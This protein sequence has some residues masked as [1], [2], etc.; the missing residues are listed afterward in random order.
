[1]FLS[2]STHD[3]S[4]VA[5]VLSSSEGS[6]WALKKASCSSVGKMGSGSSLKNCFTKPAT[7]QGRAVGRHSSP[8][9]SLAWRDKKQLCCGRRFSQNFEGQVAEKK[10]SKPRPT[11]T[12]SS[13]KRTTEPDFLNRPSVST[14][15]SSFMQ[16]STR[17]L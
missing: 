4:M 8:A 1:M 10:L 9:S 3:S 17:K 7:S 5:E 6:C 11:L 2:G 15:A 13:F 14:C 12:L 16:A